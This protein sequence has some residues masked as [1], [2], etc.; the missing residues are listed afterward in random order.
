M[1]SVIDMSKV[2][3]R[4]EVATVSEATALMQ[5]IERAARDPSV[6]VERM[7]RLLQMHERLVSKQSEAA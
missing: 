2:N 1:N 6:D 4:K 5:I 3:E 7:E